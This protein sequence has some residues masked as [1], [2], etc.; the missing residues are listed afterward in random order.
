M[1]QQ[2]IQPGPYLHPGWI[3]LQQMA[4]V[5]NAGD[6]ER[7]LRYAQNDRRGDSAKPGHPSSAPVCALGHLPPRGKAHRNGNT[8]RTTV[9]PRQRAPSSLP[10]GERWPEGPDEGRTDWTELHRRTQP[11]WICPRPRHSFRMPGTGVRIF[12]FAQND[13]RGDSA[14]PGRPSSAPVCALGHLPPRGK[15]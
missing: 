2:T 12:R 14:K 10:E 5:S 15:A 6:G 11:S 7:I 8:R 1:C 4:F 3:C 13:R 9:R